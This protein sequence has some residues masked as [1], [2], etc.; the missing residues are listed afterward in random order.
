MV[1]NW[2]L[3]TQMSLVVIFFLPAPNSGLGFFLTLRGLIPWRRSVA[4]ISASEVPD[5]S[6][7]TFL[8]WRSIPSHWN[9]FD[10]I[11]CSA[12]RYSMVTALISS[13]LV[14]PSMTFLSADWRIFGM[15]SFAAWSASS[16]ALEPAMIRRFI[17]SEI[18]MTW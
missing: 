6:P 3:K 15:P 5:I 8:P 4:L 10:F 16:M 12:I 2:R 1:A 18:G 14:T 9:I 17:A 7:L 11:A 13:R